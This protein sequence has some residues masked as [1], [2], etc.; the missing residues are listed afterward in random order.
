MSDRHT[1]DICC[2]KCGEYCY[3]LYWDD[4]FKKKSKIPKRYICKKCKKKK[5]KD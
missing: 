3:S 4:L 5:I 1:T 2:S